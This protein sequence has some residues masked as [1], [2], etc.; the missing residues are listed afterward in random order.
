MIF[1][2]PGREGRSCLQTIAYPF[3]LLQ[4][5]RGEKLLY[6]RTEGPVLES[7]QYGKVPAV[8]TF[9]SYNEE[10]GEVKVF[11]LNLTQEEANLSVCIPAFRKLRLI[12]RAVYQGNL[13]DKN[14]CGSE[15]CGIVR[16]IEDTA[17]E[18]G[19]GTVCV[20]PYS[21]TMFVFSVK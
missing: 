19:C 14:V 7:E 18:D 4:N 11:A 17:L 20:H 21:L 3:L 8:K 13:S 10:K 9:A 2:E 6:Q 12:K 16:T 5:C 15:P 1:T